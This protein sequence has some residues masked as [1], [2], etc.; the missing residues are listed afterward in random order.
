M[1]GKV[2]IVCCP[3]FVPPYL[4]PSKRQGPPSLLINMEPPSSEICLKKPRSKAEPTLFGPHLLKECRESHVTSSPAGRP[5]QRSSRCAQLPPRAPASA[6]RWA[7]TRR[8]PSAPAA[9]CCSSEPALA[10]IP[11]LTGQSSWLKESSKEASWSSSFSSPRVL[12]RR[13]AQ[14]GMLSACT[15][16]ASNKSRHSPESC[17]GSLVFLLSPLQKSCYT[18]FGGWRGKQ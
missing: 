15:L 9:R 3:E 16:V 1:G 5:K 13:E 17:S 18:F 4:P 2:I 12:S 11:R 7:G 10:A 14:S 8:C 6:A